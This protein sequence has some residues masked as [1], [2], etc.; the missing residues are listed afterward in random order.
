MSAGDAP[1]AKSAE[2]KISFYLAEIWASYQD[3]DRHR[4]LAI[5][6]QA[7]LTQQIQ[8]D[9]RYNARGKSTNELFKTISEFDGGKVGKQSLVVLN[10]LLGIDF[11]DESVK[12]KGI[13]NVVTAFEPQNDREI[14]PLLENILV[15][16]SRVHRTSFQQILQ[17]IRE[18]VWRLSQP[19]PEAANDPVTPARLYLLIILI[20]RF[21]ACLEAYTQDISKLVLLFAQSA[22]LEIRTLVAQVFKSVLKLADSSL[23]LDLVSFQQRLN[24]QFEAVQTVTCEGTVKLAKILLKQRTDMTPAF[25][26][27]SVPLGLLDKK[28][29]L[30]LSAFSV[31]PFILTT[32]PKLF[33]PDVY[34]TYYAKVRPLIA[35]K[36]PNRNEALL[37]IGNMIFSPNYSFEMPPQL[38]ERCIKDVTEQ[39]DSAEAAYAHLAFL[40]LDQQLLQKSIASIFALPLSHLLIRGFHLLLRKDPSLKASILPEILVM[41]NRSLLNM[42]APPADI[43]VSFRCL[44]KLSIG[45]DVFGSVIS[46]RLILRYC[47]LL[48]HSDLI[49]RRAAVHFILGYVQVHETREFSLALFTFVS[50]EK[51]DADCRTRRAGA[52]SRTARSPGSGGSPQQPPDPHRTGQLR[53]E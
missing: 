45:S 41:A 5:E 21:P 34:N 12:A 10:F 22:Q 20:R 47:G 17:P 16:L 53:N 6:F 14:F 39:L 9:R 8:A 11:G 4:A 25:K 18:K 52:A 48:Y 7:F 23:Q 24:V 28:A 37:S 27:D 50:T 49:V 40:S 44:R 29:D 46:H 32:S 43:E 3:P 19:V 1:L 30:R 33:T 26:F 38:L 31:I 2:S 35:K 15:Y 36:V 13:L 51:D 42:S